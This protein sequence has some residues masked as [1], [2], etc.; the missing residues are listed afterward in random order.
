M[1][2]DKSTKLTPFNGWWEANIGKF[3][4]H[5]SRSPLRQIFQQIDYP[6]GTRTCGNVGKTIEINQNAHCLI[7]HS[8]SASLE[9]KNT[10]IPLQPC[11]DD[12]DRKIGYKGWGVRAKCSVSITNVEHKNRLNCDIAQNPW[13][14]RMCLFPS[15]FDLK[16]RWQICVWGMWSQGHVQHW[17]T[18]F[19]RKKQLK[20]IKKHHCSKSL[21]PLSG[22]PGHQECV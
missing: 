10:S 19:K 18:H 8:F 6:R 15:N 21:A 14:P 4:F 16:I 13:K 3:P 1:Q 5:S 12:V 7:P 11:P 17:M 2:V 20:H 22:I 9:T